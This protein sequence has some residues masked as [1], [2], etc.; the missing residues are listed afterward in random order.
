[1][2]FIEK[3]TKTASQTYKHTTEKTS[4]IA[5]E[6]KLKSIMNQDKQ[7]IRQI[8]EKIG[9]RVYQ[10]HIRENDENAVEEI[11]R[12]CHEVDAYS[13]EIENTRMEILKLKDLKQCPYCNYEI[14]LSFSFCPN[15]G[16]KQENNSSEE[17][18]K[19][20]NTESQENENSNES[21]QE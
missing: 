3:I 21:S 4:K 10:N 13:E 1:M 12:L 9:E 5:R 7:K 19:E 16:A 11:E 6:V 15:C 14:A 20:E 18:T 2:E 8:Y 17:T